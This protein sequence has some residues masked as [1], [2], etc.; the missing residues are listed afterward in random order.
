MTTDPAPR[1]SLGRALGELNRLVGKL[2][3]KALADFDSDFP[4]WM[5]LT[6]LKEEGSLP[7]D[8]VTKALDQRMDLPETEALRLLEHAAALGHVTYLRDD[9]AVRLT[10][11][12][13]AHFAA[14]Y[15]HSRECTD[16]AFAGIDPGDLDTALT[17]ALAAKDRASAA[18]A[19]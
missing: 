19:R 16:V 11:S 15:A 1:P 6:L 18:L 9:T 2:H 17:V 12:G 3:H 7:V 13:E 8:Q 14:L 10:E 4:S 5:L